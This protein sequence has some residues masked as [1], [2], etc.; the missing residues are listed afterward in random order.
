MTR[1]VCIGDCHFGQPG[2]RND[3]RY[4][5]FDQIVAV[6]LEV[7]RTGELGAW[8]LVGDVFHA[9]STIDDR[10][11]VAARLQDMAAH[12]P[13]LMVYGN[14]DQPGDLDIFA[15]LAATYPVVVVSA[16]I[17][18]HLRLATGQTAAIF[19][20]PYVHRAGLV[21]AGVMHADLGA[22]AREALTPI[23]IDA[24]DQLRTGLAAG[25]L[26][27]MLAHMNIGGAL[28]SAGQPS[29]GLEIELDPALLARLGDIPKIFGH[30]HRPQ[31][32]HG[33]HFVG[34][35]TRNDFGEH[36]EKGFV[37]VQFSD[38]EFQVERV[39]LETPRMLHVEGE[40]TRDGFTIATINGETVLARPE[41]EYFA[42]ADVRVRYRYVKAELSAI[43]VAKVMAEFA[44][45]RLLKLDAVPVL[46][47]DVRAPEIAAAP[48]L[49][50]KAQAYCARHG[51]TWTPALAMKLTDLQRQDGP[52]LLAS[53]VSQLAVAGVQPGDGA[54]AETRV[55]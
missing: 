42:G 2:G 15:H 29:I 34:S 26:P 11:A 51:I 44:S 16:P 48:T 21:D 38:D 17:V 37:V 52:D 30:I 53:I 45:C 8:L 12:A 13:V 33:A 25:E 27:L 36:E 1:I 20:L 55:A 35:I 3:D 32:L 39:R 31:K 43:D 9:K 40:L 47:H 41:P 46:Q 7:A 24:A 6:G 23:F 49:E 5:A 54:T 22:A 4:R 28:T 50:G 14:H 18:H 10:N 19:A